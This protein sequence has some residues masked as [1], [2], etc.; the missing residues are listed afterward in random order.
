[1]TKKIQGL[2]NAPSKIR[3][4]FLPMSLHR[5]RRA[6]SAF[7]PAT[8]VVLRAAAAIPRQYPAVP[9]PPHSV[10]VTQAGG[11]AQFE[12]TLPRIDITGDGQAEILVAA[13]TAATGVARATFNNITSNLVMLAVDDGFE[14]YVPAAGTV[15]LV[16]NGTTWGLDPAHAAT[17]VVT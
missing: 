11:Q 5:T 14:V 12:V 4:P 7:A 17:I 8:P 1:M 16:N 2:C 10:I 6:Y 3:T 9:T 13:P 15:T